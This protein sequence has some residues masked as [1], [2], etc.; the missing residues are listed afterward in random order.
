MARCISYLLKKLNVSRVKLRRHHYG[1]KFTRGVLT[2]PS[3]LEI[4]TLERPWI[5]SPLHRGGK[6]FESCVPD[7][8]Y[9]VT[10]YDSEKHPN[11]YILENRD[12]DVYKYKGPE[13]RWAILIHSGNFIKDIVGCIAPGLTGEYDRVWKSKDAMNEIREELGRKE[14]VLI[15]E[16]KGAKNE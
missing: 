16:P 8:V 11:S 4:Q 15:I 9:N 1:E 3:G 10:P 12:L 6:N 2:L 7:G 14:F 13:R 5:Q